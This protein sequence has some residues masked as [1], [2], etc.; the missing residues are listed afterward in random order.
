M[1]ST[2]PVLC[3]CLSTE[4]PISDL[5]SYMRACFSCSWVELDLMVNTEMLVEQRAPENQCGDENKND[6]RVSS[7][8]KH[9]FGFSSGR[10]HKKTRLHLEMIQINIF[11]F[12][13]FSDDNIIA[14]FLPFLPL[15]QR[16]H[17][18]LVAW[19][20]IYANFVHKLFLQIY[21]YIPK[22]QPTIL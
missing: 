22:K 3:K 20:E 12:S 21:I 4:K 2:A 13:Y 19:S 7:V 18:G 15:S 10:R 1:S 5:D 16:P 14:C 17:I 8:N 9:P 11:I 6:N